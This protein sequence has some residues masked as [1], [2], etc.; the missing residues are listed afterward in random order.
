MDISCFNNIASSY[1]QK[2]FGFT[3]K[4][5]GS[6]MSITFLVLAFL[7][8]LFGMLV[9]RF[10]HRAEWI[11]FSSVIVF[12]VHLAFLLTPDGDRPAYPICFM[13]FLGLGY[14]VYA[15]VVWASISFLVKIKVAGTAY[16]TATAVQNLGLGF[17]PIVVGVI[18][19]A[20]HKGH[21]FYWVS[22]YFVLVG[23]FGIFFAVL[24]LFWDFKNGRVLKKS[25][26]RERKESFIEENKDESS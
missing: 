7:C 8:P 15:S 20:S 22:F 18:Q 9:D 16:G 26:K 1:F 19:Q 3:S 2:R 14:S 24:I 13:V 12:L 11:V 5:A 4:E 17:G 23:A 6:I 21:G 25:K 10:G